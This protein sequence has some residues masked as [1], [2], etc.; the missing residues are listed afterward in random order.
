VCARSG[1]P[2]LFLIDEILS[3]TNSQ[4]RR[5]STEII[6]EALLAEGAI[7]ALSTHDLA[8]TK[9]ADNPAVAAVLVHMASHDPDQPLQFDYRL[10]PGVARHTNALAIVRMMGITMSHVDV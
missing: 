1:K 9:I 5:A 7:G 2:V 10:H 3:G 6:I 4:D 8:L